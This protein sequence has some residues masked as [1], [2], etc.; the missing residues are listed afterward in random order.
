MKLLL[1]GEGRHGKDTVAEI[2]RDYHDWSYRSSSH[3]SA[4][5][6]IYPH[7]TSVVA[8][9]LA[10][11][12]WEGFYNNRH[13]DRQLGCGRRYWYDA[14]LDYNKKHGADAVARGVLAE[15]D[16]YVGMRSRYEFE[17]SKHLFDLIVWVDRSGHLPPEGDSMELTKED[18][19]VVL[20]N[21]GTLRDLWL[22]VDSLNTAIQGG[23][24]A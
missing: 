9:A 3:W 1:I 10:G 11:R 7:I 5:H 24:R 17:G 19:H 2:L 15:A 4:E 21:N 12:D 23:L 20:D 14:I 16:I 18:A 6:V 13:D 8:S 22:E